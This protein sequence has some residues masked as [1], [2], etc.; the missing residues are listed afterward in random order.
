MPSTLKIKPKRRKAIHKSKSRVPLKQLH[1]RDG[2]GSLTSCGKNYMASDTA[3]GE[4]E[5][6]ELI[7]RDGTD[8]LSLEAT[9]DQRQGGPQVPDLY[10]TPP[11]IKDSLTT[12]TSISQDNTVQQC[13]PHLFATGKSLLSVNA[14]GVPSLE[15]EDHV[16]FLHDAIENARYIPYDA[17]RPWVL[18]WSLTA[19][20]LLGENVEKY[21][22]RYAILTL[23]VPCLLKFF[24]AYW[25]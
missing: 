17:V 18:Y 12:D 3:I 15:R 9:F 4:D 25:N 7:S 21:Q 13:L 16:D 22:Q 20:S 14:H 8:P 10:T 24:M 1:R 6:E 23:C 5:Q 11:P 2:Y 19:F